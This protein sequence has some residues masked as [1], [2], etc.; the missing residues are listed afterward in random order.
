M[1]TLSEGRPPEDI[2]IHEQD[3]EILCV[4]MCVR[5][6]VRFVGQRYFA[7]FNRVEENLLDLE[8][9]RC[10]NRGLREKAP[11]NR[12]NFGRDVEFP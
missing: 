4:C 12:D 9:V 3:Y 5:V 6:R 7:N 11:V 2:R 10:D 8:P 1:S